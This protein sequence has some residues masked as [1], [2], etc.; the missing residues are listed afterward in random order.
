ME[1]GGEGGG[2]ASRWHKWDFIR[3][4]KITTSGRGVLMGLGSGNRGTTVLSRVPKLAVMVRQQT[5]GMGCN[6]DD[7]APELPLQNWAK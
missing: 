3:A 2:R 4:K 7:F 6:L 5:L 1:A